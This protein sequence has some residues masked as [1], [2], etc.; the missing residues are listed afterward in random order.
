MSVSVSARMPGTQP[1]VEIVVRRCVMPTSG[2]LRAAREH[3]V[4]VHHRL[5][6]AHEHEVV[7]RLDAAE[8]QHLV[9]D[10]RG[11]QVAAELHRP[12]G[13]ER[14]GQ[15]A[16]R[17]RGDADRAAAVAVAHQ[18]RLDRPPVVGVEQRLHRPVGARAPRRPSAGSRTAPRPP[19]ARAAR[20]AGRSSRRSRPRRAPPSS[21]P[22]GR[23]RRARR[24]R[25]ACR[26]AGRGPRRLWWHAC[27][28]PSTSPM[29]ASP[30]GARPSSSCS[31]GA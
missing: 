29:P 14:A 15:R 17:L 30:R 22:G 20:R 1:T 10:L 24:R 27:G 16:A 25:R 28:W 6:H 26:R 4:E 7:D 13:A 18:H 8:V 9:E 3:A 2:S 21:R 19:A 5:A 11:G 31:P 23:G 12:G